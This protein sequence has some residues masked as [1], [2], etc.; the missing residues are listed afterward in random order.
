MLTIADPLWLL[1]LPLPWLVW[2]LAQRRSRSLRGPALHHPQALLLKQLQ[3]ELDQRRRLPWRWLLGVMLITL[4]LS[5]PQWL[6][7]Q[8]ESRNF[9]LAIDVSGSMRA[10]DFSDPGGARISRLDMVKQ[11]I[12]QFM[13]SRQGDRI[14]LIIFADDAYTLSPLSTDHRLIRQ[15]LG[16][17]KNGMAGEKTALGQAIALGVKRLMAQERETRA[18]ILLTDGTHSAGDITPLTALAMAKSEGV[19]IYAVGIGRHGKV[20]FP[21][22]PVEKPDYKEV[23]MDEEILQQLATETGG[24]YY[25]AT[26]TEELRQIVKDVEQL[27]TS[28]TPSNTVINVQEGY[29]LPLIFGL[30]LIS[31]ALIK[32][33]QEVAPS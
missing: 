19:R 12:T 15:F 16:D 14:G 21:R 1:L 26:A 27:E 7:Q 17:V 11:V 18:L 32:G 10:E 8:Q 33:Q 4:A 22:G 2:F 28:A 25:R 9:I 20:P 30:C 3:S 13:A 5:R 23:P 29:P 24:H 31:I 6:E